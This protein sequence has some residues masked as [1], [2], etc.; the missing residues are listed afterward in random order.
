MVSSVVDMGDGMVGVAA[1]PPNTRLNSRFGSI[2][3]TFLTP[4]DRH[5][6]GW[7]SPMTLTPAFIS[8]TGRV[9]LL[10]MWSET[11]WSMDGPW[12]TRPLA[13]PVQIA[14]QEK[15]PA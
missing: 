9:T 5:D 8:G 11:V 14:P 1:A 7:P 15:C 13:I 3:H 6:D 4:A 2:S 10:A 12:P